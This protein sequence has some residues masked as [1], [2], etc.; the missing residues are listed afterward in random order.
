VCLL[1]SR[2]E[3]LGWTQKGGKWNEGS[4]KPKPLENINKLGKVL[5]YCKSKSH[6]VVQVEK[7]SAKKLYAIGKSIDGE[8]SHL[9]L[10]EAPKDNATAHLLTDFDKRTYCDF[11][12]GDKYTLVLLDGPGGTAS[13]CL[14]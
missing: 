5:K 10:S 4:T 12:A 2:G 6:M 3:L 11:A 9:G 8:Y 7:D 14:Y 1:T 13:E